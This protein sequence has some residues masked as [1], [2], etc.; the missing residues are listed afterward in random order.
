MGKLFKVFFTSIRQK[1][2]VL[3]AVLIILSAVGI[4]LSSVL[5]YKRSFYNRF[6]SYVGDITKQT[7]YNM[8][9]NIDYIER[10]SRDMLVNTVVQS[11]LQEVNRKRLTGYELR[12]IHKQVEKELEPDALYDSYVISF[13]VIADKG[14]EFTVQKVVGSKLRQAYSKEEIYAAN[15]S[16]VW[17]LLEGNDI[18]ISRAILNL[19]TMKPI[20]YINIVL[21]GEYF[22]DIIADTSTSYTSGSYV[23]DGEGIIVCSNNLK[24]IGSRFPVDIGTIRTSRNTYYNAID[25]EKAYYYKG[26]V[27]SNGW[28]MV[29]TI[30]VNEFDRD[31]RQFT[32]ITLIICV[33][34]ILLAFMG[35]VIFADRITKPTKRLLESMKLFGR[36]DF[37]QRVEITS[38]DEIGQISREYNSMAGNIEELVERILNMEISQKQAEIEFLKMQINPHFLYNTLDTISWLGTMA[39]NQDV[40]EIA[41]ALGNLLRAMIK[42]ESIITVRQELESVRNYLFIQGYRFGD[43]MQVTYQVDEAALD[44]VLPN[45]ILQPLIENSIIHGLEPKIGAGHLLIRIQTLSGMLSFC[46]LDDGIGMDEKEVQLLYRQCQVEKDRSSIG[47]KNVYRRLLLYY[48][49]ICG[50]S[51]ES[52]KN[53]GMKVSFCIPLEL[54]H[55]NNQK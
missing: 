23:V 18:C 42:S 41:I 21:E 53:Q 17:G 45:F 8:E 20:G 28:Q 32:H 25:S 44:Y 50:F 52:R 2:I 7:T 3:C 12:R 4:A 19:K 36:G 9:V 24:Y 16:T 10:L 30:P 34:A 31:I 55:K 1:I 22:G 47:I 33:T 15:G 29:T 6:E 11:N 51:I 13:S 39:G 43:K 5:V 37:S 54:E 38:R 49:D 40:S 35:S 27:M 14:E 48:G 26:K 46:I